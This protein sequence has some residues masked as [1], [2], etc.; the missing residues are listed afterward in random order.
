MNK[1]F[2]IMA[3]IIIM[4]CSTERKE[5]VIDTTQ[6]PEWSK[7]QVW[8][9]IFVERFNN[10]DATNDP[11][12]ENI[13]AASNFKPVPENWSITPWSTNWYE[14]EEWAD[15]IGGD[16]YSK[17]QYRR[18]GGDLQGVIDKLDYLQDLGVTALYFNPLNDAPSLHKFDARNWRHIDV[19]FGP[20]PIGDNEIIASEDPADPST[21]KWTSADSLFLKLV[22]ELHKRDMRVIV[23]YSW[24]HTGVEFW[25]FKD[26]VKNQANS[27]YKDW[28]DIESFNDPN[29]PDDEFKYVGWFNLSSL[30]EIKKVNVTT[31]RHHGYPYE[32]NINEGAKQHIFNVSERWLAP[33]GDPSKGIDG[34]RMD[35]ADQIGLGF[36]RDYRQFV[37]SVKPEAYIIGE[38]WWTKWPD[39]LMDPE[40]YMK[41]D[42]FDAVM[43]YQLYRPARYFFADTEQKLDAA[44]L[45]DSLELYWN[46]M[47]KPFRYSQMLTAATH[48]SPRLSTSFDNKGGYKVWAKPNDDPNYQTGK[49]ADET[50][51]RV[52]LYLMHQ[53]TIPGSPQIWNGD[54]MGMWGADDPDCRK[55]L[56]WPEYEFEDE[57]RNNFQPDEK[58]YDKV[59]FNQDMFD[60][61][62]KIIAIRNENPVLAFGDI[63]FLVAE[64]GKFG[65]KRTDGKDEIIVYFNMEDEPVDFVLP[66]THYTNL[67]NGEDVVGNVKLEPKS[68]IILKRK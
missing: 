3:A 62:K 17:L 12:P 36:W 40:P 26:V 10:G 27:K 4:S 46:K 59:G 22:D 41:G 23:D 45:K 48:D 29:T 25:A 11:T 8:Y 24:N 58:L 64:D 44:Q 19:N 54:E 53:F 35:V 60:F 13:H 39:I 6:P 43:F 52:K 50:Y 21:W 28:Y 15:S 56:W 33:D 47:D 16:F 1:L 32:G 57:Y 18:F 66:K 49:P 31:E 67:M 63:E 7:D 61:Y 38:I 5:K 51:E 55:P 34:Y 9:Q 42:M 14:T 65:Y 2:Y 68:G 30:P 37:K 20:D